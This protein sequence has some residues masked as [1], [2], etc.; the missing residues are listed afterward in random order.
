MLI[1][2]VGAGGHGVPGFLGGLD[3]RVR[4][5][6][7]PVRQ[8]EAVSV[9][10]PH[11]A[12]QC[13]GWALGLRSVGRLD[14]ECGWGYKCKIGAGHVAGISSQLLRAGWTSLSLGQAV[15]A[16]TGEPPY[17]QVPCGHLVPTWFA[18]GYQLAQTR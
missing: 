6:I 12:N 18:L 8:Q 3:D 5:C 13:P 17:D 7:V 10:G 1:D 11:P 2:T 14:R 9:F 4:C 15:M 16:I